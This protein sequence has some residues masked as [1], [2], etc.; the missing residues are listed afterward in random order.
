M[1]DQCD[2]KVYLGNNQY[3]FVKSAEDAIL[4]GSR[5]AAIEAE[6]KRLQKIVESSEEGAAK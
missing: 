6:I 3:V 5:F 4:L 2:W 1:S